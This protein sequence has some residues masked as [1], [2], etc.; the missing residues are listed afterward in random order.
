[1]HVHFSHVRHFYHTKMYTHLAH[2]KHAYL[3]MDI[4]KNLVK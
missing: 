3:G 2:V 4:I 1:M